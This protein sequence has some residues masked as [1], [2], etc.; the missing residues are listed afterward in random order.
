MPRVDFP[1]YLVSDRH[2]TRDRPLVSLIRVAV[3]A[4][5]RAVQLREKDLDTRTLL[6]LTEEV[7]R[8]TRENR[9]LLLVNDRLDLAMA[10]GG[11]GVHLPS[12]SIPVAVTRRIL[13]PDRVIGVSGDRC[14]GAYS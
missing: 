3:E 1:L 9:A 8:I 7:L 4:G 6:G 12:S 11:N 10:A 5:V 14:V 2:Q 13:G